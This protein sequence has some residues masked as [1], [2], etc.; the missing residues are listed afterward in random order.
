VRNSIV[1]VSWSA[2]RARK[3]EFNLREKTP[4]EPLPRSWNIFVA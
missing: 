3:L 2:A 1:T 4:W